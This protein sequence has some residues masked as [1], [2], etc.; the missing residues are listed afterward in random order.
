MAEVKFHSLVKPTVKTPFHID[1][2]WWKENDREWRV[3]LKSLLCTE[4][5]DS[6]TEIETGE[7]L[8]WID[9]E[10]AEVKQVDGLQH[11][12]LSHCAQQEEFLGPRTALT[13]GIFRLFMKNGNAPMTIGEIAVQLNRKPTPIIKTLASGRV[14]KGIRPILD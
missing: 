7:M 10:T 6:F 8:D 12:L 9:P 3:H 1:F 14:Y 5:Q 11:I 4:H 13:E 2:S